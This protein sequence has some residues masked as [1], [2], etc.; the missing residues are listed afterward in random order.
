MF[1]AFAGFLLSMQA[2]RQLLISRGT[3]TFSNHFWNHFL[4]VINI[5]GKVMY[6]LDIFQ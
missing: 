6:R 1:L 5:V 3:S 2:F 4:Q